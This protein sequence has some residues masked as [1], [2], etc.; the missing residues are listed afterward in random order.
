MKTLTEKY[1]AVLEGRFTK[2]QFLRDVRLAHPNLVTQYNGYEDAVSILKN[3]GMLFEIKEEE[4][5]DEM[6]TPRSTNT[7]DLE[8]I[9]AMAEKAGEFVLDAQDDLEMLAIAWEGGVPKDKVIEVL[10]NYDLE[11]EDV[12]G[13]PF[14]RHNTD[15]SPDDTEMPSWMLENETVDLPHPNFS[16]SVLDK[17]IRYELEK[18]RVEYTESS[19]TSE[20]YA[21]AKGKAEK[22]LAKDPTYYLDLKTSKKRKTDQME[23]ATSKNTVDKVNGMSKVKPVKESIF[24][25]PQMGGILSNHYA[26]DKAAV[27][28]VKILV[29][30]GIPEDEAIEKIAEKHGLRV[31]YLA[32]Q[33]RMSTSREGIKE[34]VK[35]VIK[36]ILK[37]EEKPITEN[38]TNEEFAFDFTFFEQLYKGISERIAE[39]NGTFDNVF[40]NP[41][42]FAAFAYRIYTSNNHQPTIKAEEDFKEPEEIEGGMAA[43]ELGT[44]LDRVDPR[45]VGDY[46]R[47]LR[48]KRN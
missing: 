48:K 13:T 27:S 18:A 39:Y 16:S 19:P 14:P 34:A 5:T 24:N 20:E 4:Y 45:T 26:E 32:K 43:A 28:K 23:P 47:E 30:K 40:Y 12:L 6:N 36:S 7:Y 46:L 3:K 1:N 44:D 31:E 11:L 33:V 10:N 21:K 41:N 9:L 2:S 8:Q 22:A 38:T 29:S 15:G 42:A 35:T 37:E 25:T 17:A